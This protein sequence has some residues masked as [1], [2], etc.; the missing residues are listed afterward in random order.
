MTRQT[1]L[2]STLLLGFLLAALAAPGALTAKE[3]EINIDKPTPDWREGPVR[4]I[5]S[6]DEDKAYKTL[7]TEAQRTDFIDI[8][9]KR[10]DPTPRTDYNEFKERFR[11]R[12]LDA[13]RLYGETAMPGWKTDMGKVYMLVGPP[14][15]MVRDRIARSKRGTVIWIYRN[16]PFPDLAPNTVIAFAQDPSGEYVLSTK[17][18]WDSDVAHG[19]KLMGPRATDPENNYLM[20]A[21]KDPLLLAQGIPFSQGEFETN[22]IY[23]R[24]QQLPPKDEA[25]LH[26]V[27]TAKTSFEVFPIRSRYSFFRSPTSQTLVAVTLAIRTTSVQY[28]KVGGKEQ[29]DVDPFGKFVDQDHP[30][31]QAAISSDD[32]FAAAPQ[33]VNAGL[34]DYLLFQA[35]LPLKPGRYVAVYGARDN[36]AGK[37]GTYREQIVVPDL[38]EAEKL[39]VSSVTLA[40]SLSPSAQEPPESARKFSPFRLGALDVVQSG[41]EDF[42]KA[43]SLNL[44]Y[45]IYNAR[46]DDT[47]AVSLDVDY[48]YFAVRPAG[49]TPLGNIHVG[50]SPS[51]VQAYSLPLDRFP[52]GPY[53]L[54]ITVT[55]RIQGIKTTQEVLFNVVQ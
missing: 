41:G 47:G 51:P 10:R 38:S 22:F 7:K 24:M 13:N 1:Q 30:E 3:Y 29:P 15:E 5:I 33:N 18:T 6:K 12:S 40:Q 11:N 28:Q 44:Y 36:V 54:R 16:P 49:D 37:V 43:G 19:I 31:N 8:F 35:L 9:W 34:D 26:D 32:V 27:V 39:A 2:I 4:Y 53:K 55:D 50:P 14:D 52:V 42:R 21:G 25:I 45:Q 48:D 23:G 46:K 20:I 17:P